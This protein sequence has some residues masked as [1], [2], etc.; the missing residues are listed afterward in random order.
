MIVFDL[1]PFHPSV[2]L[3]YP[4]YRVYSSLTLPGD[5]SPFHP[6]GHLGQ[7]LHYRVYRSLTRPVQLLEESRGAIERTAR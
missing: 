4:E 7:L 2:R 6:P 1:L 3:K 5:L